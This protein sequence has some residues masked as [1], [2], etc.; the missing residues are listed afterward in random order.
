MLKIVDKSF[1]LGE[2]DTIVNYFRQVGLFDQEIVEIVNDP[3]NSEDGR[4]LYQNFPLP[5]VTI[6]DFVFI[7]LEIFVRTESNP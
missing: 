6:R 1:H 4:M 7:D 5:N 3:I 2:A